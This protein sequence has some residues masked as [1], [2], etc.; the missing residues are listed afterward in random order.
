M[1][2]PLLSGERGNNSP[3]GGIV[4]GYLRI[5]L[6]NTSLATRTLIA[7]TVLS[8]CPRYRTIVV[9]FQL[10]SVLLCWTAITGILVSL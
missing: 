1:A 6:V 3:A 2:C 8:E 9:L 4:P 10:P 5:T 7:N